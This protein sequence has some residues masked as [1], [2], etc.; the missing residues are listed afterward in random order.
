MSEEYSM[1]QECTNS[2]KAEGLPDG[3][4]EI[5]I[6]VPKRFAD[7]WLVKLSKLTTTNKEINE[8]EPPDSKC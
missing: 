3:S 7:L 4:L 8:Y 6:K 2:Y 5:S 1:V